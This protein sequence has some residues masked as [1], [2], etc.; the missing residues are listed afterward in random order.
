[1]LI[2]S[3]LWPKGPKFINGPVYCSSLNTRFGIRNSCK[4]K[5]QDIFLAITLLAI[6]LILYRN[7]SMYYV[8]TNWAQVY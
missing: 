4:F 6:I 3:D 5:F 1:M 2:Y 7:V 8:N